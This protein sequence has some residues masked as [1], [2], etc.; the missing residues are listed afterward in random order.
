MVIGKGPRWIKRQS[1]KPSLCSSG[2]AG[3]A[4]TGRQIHAAH[5][6]DML[7][8]GIHRRSLKSALDSDRQCDHFA[9]ECRPGP[10][11]ALTLCS[12]TL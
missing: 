6:T 1:R 11:I 12:M 5:A 2:G 8:A 3:L 4:M 9:W 10:L 7:K